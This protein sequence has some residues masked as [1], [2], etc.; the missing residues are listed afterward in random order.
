VSKREAAATL[1]VLRRRIRW[2]PGKAAS[3]LEKRKALGHLPAKSSIA[4]Y[5]RLIRAL[6]QEPE[7]QV[8]LYRFGSERYYAVRGKMRRTEWLVIST[9]EGVI[10]TAFPPGVME[11]Y[12]CKRG[13]V[14]IGTIR[15]VLT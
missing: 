2:K 11:D 7:H 1:K 13:F 3:H 4:E 6:I 10:E 9:K 8:Y 5:N 14:L 15:E 12:L